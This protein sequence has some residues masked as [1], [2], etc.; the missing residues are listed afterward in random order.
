[1]LLV[2]GLVSDALAAFGLVVLLMCR[3]TTVLGH[4]GRILMQ[5]TR[6]AAESTRYEEVLQRAARIPGVCAI[7]DGCFWDLDGEGKGVGAV[8]CVLAPGSTT[9]AAMHILE[10]VRAL[11]A[12]TPAARDLTVHLE[13]G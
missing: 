12:E 1:L 5:A 9:S 8:R 3:A 7:Y 11:F 2:G 4:D 10:Q 6:D 13:V